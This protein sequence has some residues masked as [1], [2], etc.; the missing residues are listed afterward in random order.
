MGLKAPSTVH[1]LRLKTKREILL[2]EIEAEKAKIKK[3]LEQVLA[4]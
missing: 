4:S 2:Q 3:E 1:V